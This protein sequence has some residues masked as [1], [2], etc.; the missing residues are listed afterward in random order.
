MA[1]GTGGS[2]PARFPSST[3][4]T[5]AVFLNGCGEQRRDAPDALMPSAGFVQSHRLTG[6]R[7]IDQ[8]TTGI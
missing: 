5:P 3:M 4:Q 1:T 6:L 7:P 8:R 2:P